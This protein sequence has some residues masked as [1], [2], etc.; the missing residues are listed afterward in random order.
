MKQQ[1]LASPWEVPRTSLARDDH[2]WPVFHFSN[3][4]CCSTSSSHL[5]LGFILG[6]LH[7]HEQNGLSVFLSHDE[8]WESSWSSKKHVDFLLFPFC[9]PV[10]CRVRVGKTFGPFGSLSNI[11][12]LKSSCVV[13]CQTAYK[14]VSFLDV[15]S[16]PA[17]CVRPPW[18]EIGPKAS[19]YGI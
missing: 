9:P 18:W 16:G 19:S 6:F 8:L 14:T 5:I 13:L 3:W 7:S 2:G 11:L 4:P 12:L 10:V 15:M 1:P 17:L